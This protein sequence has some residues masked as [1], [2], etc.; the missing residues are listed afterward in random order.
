V[1]V[2]KAVRQTKASRL[3]RLAVRMMFRSEIDQGLPLCLR[4]GLEVKSQ[5]VVHRC[6][7]A[8]KRPGNELG[9]LRGCGRG[10]NQNC[11]PEFR[12]NVTGLSVLQYID[13]Q[14]YM[15]VTSVAGLPCTAIRRRQA[16]QPGRR[17][18]RLALST[19]R[20]QRRYKR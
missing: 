16:D 14:P 17:Y 3:K 9:L 5:Y 2:Y 6:R 15:A 11:I 13:N 18:G 8:K 1:L 7:F 4:R 20:R 19:Q 12:A 10:V